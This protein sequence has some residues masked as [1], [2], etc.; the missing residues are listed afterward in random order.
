MSRQP[1]HGVDLY[2]SD[3]WHVRHRQPLGRCIAAW[4]IAM[5]VHVCGLFLLTHY[6]A[7]VTVAEDSAM[8]VTLLPQ[9]PAL[10]QLERAPPVSF[11]PPS[12]AIFNVPV[13]DVAPAPSLSVAPAGPTISVAA[14]ARGPVTLSNEL[15]VNCP[16]RAAPAYPPASMRLR[17]VGNVLLRVEL[18]EQGL[19]SLVQVAES[20]GY[21]RLDEAAQRAVRTWRCTPARRNGVVTRSV[22]L[23]PINFVLNAN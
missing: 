13:I 12:V 10:H 1:S 17:E 23:Q 18:D 22:A 16:E 2:T 21:P 5:A 19:V 11:A 7:F 3:D 8:A 14:Q 4:S 9:S 6:Q 20:S 15:A